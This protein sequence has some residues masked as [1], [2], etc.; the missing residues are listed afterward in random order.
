MAIEDGL[1]IITECGVRR[2]QMKYNIYVGSDV[3]AKAFLCRGKAIDKCSLCW[4]DEKVLE[5]SEQEMRDTKR[6]VIRLRS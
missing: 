1:G 3:Q 6:Q 5:C 2:I 4:A